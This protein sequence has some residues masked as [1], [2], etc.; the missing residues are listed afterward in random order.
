MRHFLAV[1]LLAFVGCAP[2]ASESAETTSS[3]RQ[4]EAT[5][6]STPS[7][8]ASDGVAVPGPILYRSATGVSLIEPGGLPRVILES[9]ATHVDWSPDGKRVVF[10]I[11]TS[12]GKTEIWTARSDSSHRRL[13]FD[14]AE[15]CD[16]A[17]DPAWSPDGRHIVFWYNGPSVPDQQPLRIVD[18]RSGSLVRDIKLG[19]GLAPVYP[20]WSPH[21]SKIVV[22]LDFYKKVGG[23]WQLARQ[24]LATIATRA[25]HPRPFIITPRTMSPRQ[26]SWSQD[27]SRIAFDAGNL[28]PFSASGSASNIWTVAPDGKAL[29]QVTHQDDGDD[30][31]ALADWSTTGLL[32]T[33]I[34]GTSF[35]LA[36]IS[37]SGSITDLVDGDGKPVQG[38]R[39]RIQPGY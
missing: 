22:E 33:R 23:E 38:L 10:T 18:A 5:A 29:R 30:W 25:S 19:K 37:D 31:V 24:S 32:G 15:G 36:A 39:P 9:P 20:D 17:D 6:P 13:L 26:P 21:G 7:T 11:E 8:A 28:D 34:S 1:V 3:S 12:D 16:F 35:N 27:G 4:S 14:C 2:F